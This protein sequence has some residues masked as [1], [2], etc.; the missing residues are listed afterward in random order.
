MTGLDGN[1]I[2]RFLKAVGER[3][4]NPAQIFLL[5]G[6]ALCLLGSP[7]PTLDID[8]VG[9]DL[10]KDELQKIMEETA[11]EFGLDVEAVPVEKFIPLPS[12]KQRQ[13]ILVGTFGKVKVYILDPYSI[14]LSKIDRGFDTDLDDVLFLIQQ[15]LIEIKALEQIAIA[16]S[17][18]GRE[19]DINVNELLSHLQTLKDRLK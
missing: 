11:R 17:K 2:T 4:A 8:Y 14:A 10:K 19:F 18:H 13:N 6:S 5:G 7:R 16:A 15:G 12:K 9:D 1:Q 3:Y